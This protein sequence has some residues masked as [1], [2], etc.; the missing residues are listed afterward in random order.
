MSGLFGT[1]PDS[2][3]PIWGRFDVARAHGWFNGTASLKAFTSGFSVIRFIYHVWQPR[4]R[5][6]SFQNYTRNWQGPLRAWKS[7]KPGRPRYDY[8]ITPSCIHTCSRR[9]A[10]EARWLSRVK[11][12]SPFEAQQTL[13]L[14]CKEIIE[15]KRWLHPRVHG[16]RYSAL[17]SVVLLWKS[18]QLSDC[19]PVELFRLCHG[20]L[21]TQAGS[22]IWPLFH[23]SD[24]SNLDN[25]DNPIFQRDCSCSARSNLYPVSPVLPH[26]LINDTPILFNLENTLQ[27]VHHWEI[28]TECPE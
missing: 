22:N 18:V 15:T 2:G 12:I 19:D 16:K 17:N 1:P 24:S 14:A 8:V 11:W 21:S 3:R 6:H 9:P 5:N 13:K 4:V 27:V 7:L 26:K 28:S 25:L 10:E 20:E 23:S